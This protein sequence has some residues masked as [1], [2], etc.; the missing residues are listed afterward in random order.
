MAGPITLRHPGAPRLAEALGIANATAWLGDGSLSLVAQ[1]SRNGG[2]FA[3]DSFEVTA[4]SLHASGAL[5]VQATPSGPS[6]TG[7]I[8]AETLP[9][10]LPSLRSA[11]PLPF[12]WLTGWQ[13]AVKLDVGRVWPIR[14]R[15]CR[16][17]RPQ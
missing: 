8:A 17:S 3:A 15:F 16:N 7:R 6:V 4:G 10:P 13:A 11:D 5:A 14:R 9:L 12:A 1:V 2:R